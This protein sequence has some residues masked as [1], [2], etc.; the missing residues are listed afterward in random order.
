MRR[1]SRTLAETEQAAAT[2]ADARDEGR[3]D[4]RTVAGR[5]FRHVN[6]TWTDTRYRA[7]GDVVTIE[8]FSPAYFALLRALP[9]LA[10]YWKAYTNVIVAGRSTSIK[11]GTGG[12]Q[13]LDASRI[14]ETVQ[15]FRN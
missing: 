9:E 11:L 7:R 14:A 10:P 2:L 12:A 13:Q 3:A 1:E 5:V 6:G 15:R 8:P 4:T